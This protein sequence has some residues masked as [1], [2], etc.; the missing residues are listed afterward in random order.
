MVLSLQ[1]L[2]SVGRRWQMDP[3]SCLNRHR[4]VMPVPSSESTH[5]AQLYSE[6]LRVEYCLSVQRRA[7]PR[8]LAP[9]LVRAGAAWA[10]GRGGGCPVP[11]L[12]ASHSRS[13]H[14]LSAQL[15]R[16]RG[17]DGACRGGC[18]LGV[19]PP[20]WRTLGGRRGDCSSP[21]SSHHSL[22]SCTALVWCCGCT[23]AMTA[24]IC[25]AAGLRYRQLRRW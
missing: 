17:A 14:R 20:P 11:S 7:A 15:R 24:S 3:V 4:R 6:D 9:R 21:A 12:P 2:T 1:H 19:P 22:A 23:V 13:R 8:S 18:G 5:A 25:G 16:V 10:R